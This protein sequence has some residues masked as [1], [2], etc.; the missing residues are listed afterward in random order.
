[1]FIKRSNLVT[2]TQ[3]NFLYSFTDYYNMLKLFA[4][5]FLDNV[6]LSI[7]H[8]LITAL[9]LICYSDLLTLTFVTWNISET[10]WSCQFPP[11]FM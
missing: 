5:L 7:M 9:V 8:F 2:F 6:M 3:Q 11:R 4:I 10:M 1:M